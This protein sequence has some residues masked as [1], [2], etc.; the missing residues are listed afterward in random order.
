M[1]VCGTGS[2][3][4]DATLDT[5]KYGSKLASINGYLNLKAAFEERTKV[6]VNDTVWNTYMNWTENE[7]YMT[8]PKKG[9]QSIRGGDGTVKGRY[10]VNEVPWSTLTSQKG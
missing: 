7:T 1:L 6:K 2:A 10:T 8:N 4:I 5:S 3:D 9:D